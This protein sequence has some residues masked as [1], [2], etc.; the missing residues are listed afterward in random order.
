MA[1]GFAAG[2]TMSTAP[3]LTSQR[4]DRRIKLAVCVFLSLIIWVVF[5][6]TLGHDFINFDDDQYVYQNSEV[7]YGLTLDGFKW[8]L[9]HSHARLWHPL[10]TLSHMFDCQ[11]YGLKPAGHHFTNLLLHNIGA[12]L[13]FLVL[14][15]MT[16]GPRPTGAI[17]ASAFVAAVFAI[18]PLR[19]ESVAWIT[20]R[21]D[22]LSGVFLM[23][24][25]AAYARY[26]RAPSVSR[27][28]TMSICVACGLMSKATFV[29]VPLVLLLLDYWPLR[30][31]DSF[32]AWR[33][34]VLEKLPLLALSAAAS[35]ATIVAQRITMP[36]LEQLPL[37]PRIKN[38]VVGLVLYLRQMFWPTDLAIFY[39]HPHDQLNI[40]IVLGCGAL[41]VAITLLVILLRKQRPYLFV[42]WFWFLILVGPV[43][44]IF[45]AGLQG[46]ADR[47]T[48]LPHIGITIAL[49]WAIVDVTQQ[50]RN[51]RVVLISTASCVVVAFATIAW[52]QTTYWQDSISIW[53]R[54][55]AVTANNQ[56]AHR[57]LAA[58][59]WTRGRIAESKIHSRTADIIHAQTTL[60]DYPLDIPARDELGRLLIQSRDTS[61]AIKQWETSLQVDPNDGNALNN[62]AWVLATFPEETVRNGKRAVE[63]ASKAAALP[64][65]ESP[66]VLRTLAAAYAEAGDF[67]NAI[68]TA[69]RALDLAKAKNDNSMVLTLSHD[70][71]LYQSS[72]PYREWPPE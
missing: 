37:L 62:L 66:L 65:G 53:E 16:G 18:H 12:V 15:G 71:V 34:L 50:W 58:A 30:R 33:N 7:S 63:L 69:Q 38:A 14:S 46:R 64:G 6:Q 72:T 25:L 21:K 41:L 59:L 45:Q 42:G 36:T 43:S 32:R 23:L 28:L 24:T 20:E 67:P 26:A 31:A 49:T 61:G 60:K 70:I 68:S 47:F 44:G 4:D 13:L 17:W 40:W 54:A 3:E 5:A 51:R 22:V 10:T 27:Y 11:L 9:T 29:P 48:Y 39:P 52:K 57:N 8:L 55:L 19:V 2:L 1:F 35:A 56:T